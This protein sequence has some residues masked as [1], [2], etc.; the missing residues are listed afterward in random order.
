ML[1]YQIVVVLQGGR[2]SCTEAE[3]HA[4]LDRYVELGGNFIDT[5][6]MYQN[7]QSEEIIGRWLKKS[8]PIYYM[9]KKLRKLH[10]YFC[11]SQTK[12]RV[13]G[14]NYQVWPNHGSQEP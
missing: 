13:T 9:R 5:A 14:A 10:S 2:P 7:G 12:A 6:D 1:F 3:S 11:I 8:V 4:I